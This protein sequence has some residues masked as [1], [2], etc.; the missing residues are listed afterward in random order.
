ME[1]IIKNMFRFFLLYS[2]IKLEIILKNI[3]A[4]KLLIIYINKYIW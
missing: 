1:M 3:A 2:I 4:G